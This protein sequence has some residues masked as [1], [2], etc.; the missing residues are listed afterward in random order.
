MT[1]TLSTH[2]GVPIALELPRLLT[3]RSP[4]PSRR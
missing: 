4:R 3:S 2:D 1:V